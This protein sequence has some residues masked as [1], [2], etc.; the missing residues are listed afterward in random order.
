MVVDVT[1]VLKYSQDVEHLQIGG[2]V[3][4]VVLNWLVKIIMLNGLRFLNNIY[5]SWM[6]KAG[7]KRRK[8]RVACLLFNDVWWLL[9]RSRHKTE[10]FDSH[11]G[12]LLWKYLRLLFLH[13]WRGNT[14]LCGM[15]YLFVGKMN[16]LFPRDRLG[17]WHRPVMKFELVPK[18]QNQ[19]QVTYCWW[20]KSCTSW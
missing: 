6:L 14:S 7:K 13:L 4:L 17:P 5:C 12:N 1:V 20:K 2:D 3:F 15:G 8:R 10:V 16:F 19:I 9:L 18:E 11:H